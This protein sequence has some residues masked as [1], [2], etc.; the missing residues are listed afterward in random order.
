MRIWPIVLLGSLAALGAGAWLWAQDEP[1]A[2]QAA[3]WLQPPAPSPDSFAY[4]Q[5]LGLDAPAG[6]DPLVVGRQLLD[7]H[8]QWR[9]QHG[10]SEPLVQPDDERIALPRPALCALGEPACL[11][12]LRQ[13]RAALAALALQHAELLQRYDKLLALSDY[14]TLAAP[15]MDQPLANFTSLQQANRLRAAQ[16]LALALDGR[17]DQALALLQLDVYLLR[18]WLPRADN[19]ILKMVLVRL[20]GSDL[21]AIA[22]LYDAGLLPRPAA[23]PAL[24][25]AERSL[26]AAMQ[27]EFALVGAGLLSLLD[28]PQTAAELG[29]ARWQLRWLYKPQMTVNDSLPQYLQVAQRSHLAAPAWVQTLGAAAHHEVSPWRRLRNP[30]GAIL[31]DVAVPD[32]NRYLARLHDLDA[33]LA[34]FN[35]LGQAVPEAHNP[36]QPGQRA[37]WNGKRQAYCFNGPLADEQGL[38]CLP[39]TPPPTQ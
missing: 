20:L 37:S 5:L 19:L 35:T 16:A 15:S 6:Q 2:P 10:F 25:E 4:Y 17:G 38:R 9:A 26:A 24:S 36:Y 34:L 7:A 23:L 11:A 33:K 18:G 8:R 3:A 28:D 14:R 31:G 22:A 21:D 13:D 1:L 32:F 29:V 39:W 27:H 12:R 30:V